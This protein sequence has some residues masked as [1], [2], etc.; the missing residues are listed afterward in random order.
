MKFVTALVLTALLS[1]AVVLFFGWW[2]FAITSFVVAVVIPQSYGRAFLAG[3][4]GIF[5]LWLIH[6]ILLDSANGHLLSTK[7]ADL[8]SLNGS[9]GI[10][11]FIT[12]LSGGLIS[13]FAAMTGSLLLPLKTP[14]HK[15]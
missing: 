5:L 2:T 1:F 9:Y 3:F 12:A 7:V 4:L 13:G 14:S 11:L 15:I 8:F 10:L 6:A